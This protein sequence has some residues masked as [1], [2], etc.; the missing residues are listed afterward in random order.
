MVP[1]YTGRLL[2]KLFF[3]IAKQTGGVKENVDDPPYAESRSEVLKTVVRKLW[4]TRAEL[5]HELRGVELP[6]PSTRKP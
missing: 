6:A 2:D 1:N 4:S 5:H 3:L